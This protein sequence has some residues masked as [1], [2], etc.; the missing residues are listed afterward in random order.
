MGWLEKSG[1]VA[2]K[3]T[4]LILQNKNNVHFRVRSQTKGG[5]TIKDILFFHNPYIEKYNDLAY[6]RTQK[7]KNNLM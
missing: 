3:E 4:M 7:V 6:D 1:E 5:G 2:L